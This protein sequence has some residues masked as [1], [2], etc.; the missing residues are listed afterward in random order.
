MQAR[1][2][3]LRVLLEQAEGLVSIEQ[4]TGENG[5]PNILIRLERAKIISHGKPA[6][7]DFLRKLQVFKSMADVSSGATLYNSYSEVDS[8]W[9]GIR[10]IVLARKVPRKMLVQCLPVLKEGMIHIRLF[11]YIIVWLPYG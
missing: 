3:I 10:E 8:Q 2:V 4:T 11:I 7:G 5:K 6:I 1:F 9:L